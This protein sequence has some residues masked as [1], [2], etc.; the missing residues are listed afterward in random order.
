L[1]TLTI[2][3]T[4]DAMGQAELVSCSSDYSTRWLPIK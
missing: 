4:Y 2:Y 3:D 1:N